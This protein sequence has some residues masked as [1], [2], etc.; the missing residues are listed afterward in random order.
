M[1]KICFISAYFNSDVKFSINFAHKIK[2]RTGS[3]YHDDLVNHDRDK[4][5]ISRL[6]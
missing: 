3:D 4:V 5:D 6:Y 1:K 2:L